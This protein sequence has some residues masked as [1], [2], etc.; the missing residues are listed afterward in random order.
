[1]N[2]EVAPA[3][4][5]DRQLARLSGISFELIRNRRLDASHGDRLDAALH[6]L[7]AVV[8]RLAFLRPPFDLGNVAAAADAHDAGLL[9]F[10][11]LQRF[12]PPGTHGDKR[13][14]VDEMMGFLRQFADAGVAVLVVAAVGRQRDSKGRTSYAADSLSLA[15]FR[16]SSELEFGADDAFMLAPTESQGEVVLKH[17]KARHSEPRDVRLR[18]DGA[19]QSFTP[20]E[21][22]LPPTRDPYG[23]QAALAAMWN[24]DDEGSDA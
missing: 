23:L 5:L 20:L 8:D 24:R 13:G 17:L 19:R 1:A 15:S 4:L 2:V 12:K 21:A 6:A 14:A 16:E 3:V 10:D 7:E 18:F 11:Y 9:V 22:E